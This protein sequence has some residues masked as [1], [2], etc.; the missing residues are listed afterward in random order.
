[1]SKSTLKKNNM[2]ISTFSD[3]EYKLFRYLSDH[4]ISGFYFYPLYKN[5]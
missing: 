5:S 3:V 1:M 4:T 2:D